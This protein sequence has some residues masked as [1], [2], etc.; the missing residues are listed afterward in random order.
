MDDKFQYFNDVKFC[1]DEKTGYYLNGSI[2]ERMHRYVWEHYCG[3]IPEGFQV[4][5]IDGDKSNNVIDNLALMTNS[6]HQRLHGK[7]EARKAMMR[8][9]AE[10]MRPA[11]IKW[12]K[13]EEGRKWHSEQGKLNQERVKPKKYIC[14]HCG[15]EFYSKPFGRHHDFCSNACKAANRRELGVDNE[16]R[17]CPVCGKEFMVNK[18]SKTRFC[19]RECVGINRSE[20]NE[21]KRRKGIPIRGKSKKKKNG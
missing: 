5:H 6:A 13:S 18:Y 11:A 21:E 15:K 4:H 1:K 10:E 7:E 20:V 14:K 19:S 3:K 16:T 12:H 2:H 8:K 17:I 9:R